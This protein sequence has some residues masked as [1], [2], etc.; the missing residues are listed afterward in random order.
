LF[1]TDITISRIIRVTPLQA[2][3]EAV[4]DRLEPFVPMRLPT[5]KKPPTRSKKIWQ[6]LGRNGWTTLTLLD[7]LMWSP[8]TIE[9]SR[10]GC[11]EPCCDTT[12]L[13]FRST[14]HYIPCRWDSTYPK[15]RQ[16]RRSTAIAIEI[17]ARPIMRSNA[18]RWVDKALGIE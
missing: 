3:G 13:R 7:N 5:I 17:W 9:I 15:V 12:A 4:V 2:L 18:P 11:K 16:C 6:R 14:T 10:I 8:S 1:I